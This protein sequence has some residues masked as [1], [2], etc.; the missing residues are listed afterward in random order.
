MEFRADVI[1]LGAG[2]SGITTAKCLK[3]Y[4]FSVL[5]LEKTDEIGGLWTFREKEDYG[6]MRCT[7][8]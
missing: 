7:H 5:V 8:M 4:G 2:I 1:V 3:E 6:V